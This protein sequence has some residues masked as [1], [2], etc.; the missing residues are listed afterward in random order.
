MRR[1]GS[2]AGAGGG[3]RWGGARSAEG[4]A[5]REPAGKRGACFLML[6]AA[7]G[8]GH[9]LSQLPFAAV[10]HHHKLSGVNQH[11]CITFQSW[12]SEAQLTS[13]CCCWTCTLS[14]GTRRELV[15]LPLPAS[16]GPLVS[17]A[18]WPCPPAPKQQQCTFSPFLWLS[19]PP[20]SSAVQGPCDDTG[21]FWM[22]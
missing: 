3:E 20:P 8:G 14:G 2:G 22:A 1:T 5:G 10:T 19:L 12:S 17:W 16:R 4:G 21:P 15:P 7:A 6:T 9:H 13:H 11:Q 18:P